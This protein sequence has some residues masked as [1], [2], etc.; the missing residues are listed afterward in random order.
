MLGKFLQD[1]QWALRTM[2]DLFILGNFRAGPHTLCLQIGWE[3]PSL[4]RA[5][6]KGSLRNTCEQ[7]SVLCRLGFPSLLID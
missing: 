4:P 6:M 2:N 1:K 5:A 7:L 3:G